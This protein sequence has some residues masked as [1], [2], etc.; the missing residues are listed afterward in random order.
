MQDV[1]NEDTFLKKGKSPVAKIG[2]Y[3]PVIINSTFKVDES[4]EYISRTYARTTR[5]VTGLEILV[6]VNFTL[7][8]LRWMYARRT[9]AAPSTI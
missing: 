6:E 9:F 4:R 5:F 2:Y 8:R 3:F 7:Y 1:V